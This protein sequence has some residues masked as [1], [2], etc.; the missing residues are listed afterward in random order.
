M[1]SINVPNHILVISFTLSFDW[2][3]SNRI[4]Y[5]DY[6]IKILLL[7]MVFERVITFWRETFDLSVAWNGV[8]NITL[9]IQFVQYFF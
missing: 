1:C 7:E 9:N 2:E 3:I 8:G 6:H 4:P 5:I